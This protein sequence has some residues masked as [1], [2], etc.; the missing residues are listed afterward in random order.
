[1]N[2]TKDKRIKLY[3]EIVDGIKFIK[4]YG[5]EIAFKKII[6]EL[7]QRE[8]EYYLKSNFYQSLNLSFS[9]S[10]VYISIFLFFIVNEYLG[11]TGL[12]TATILAMLQ[13]INALKAAMTDFGSGIAA[14]HSIHV[15]LQR[16]AIVL[17]I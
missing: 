11:Q 9:F 3:S 16:C 7:R 12:T 6:Q 2:E 14:Y 8:V 10:S 1:M 4:I 5:W 13:G 15:I 17:N